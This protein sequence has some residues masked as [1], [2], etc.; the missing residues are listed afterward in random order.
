[1]ISDITGLGESVERHLLVFTIDTLD[2]DPELFNFVD[3]EA[4]T[5][6]GIEESLSFVDSLSELFS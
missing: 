1:M 3:G 6:V 2:L 4:F 5:V